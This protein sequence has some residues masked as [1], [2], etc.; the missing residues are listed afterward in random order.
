MSPPT[1]K[2]PKRNVVWR[3][4]DFV[5][6]IIFAIYI[7]PAAKRSLFPDQMTRIENILRRSSMEGYNLAVDRQN[8][9]KIILTVYNGGR[10]VTTVPAVRACRPTRSG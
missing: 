10:S 6:A 9:L 3:F 1:K 2:A 4:F 5:I 7:V 8:D